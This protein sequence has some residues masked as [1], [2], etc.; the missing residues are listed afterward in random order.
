MPDVDLGNFAQSAKKATVIALAAMVAA[1]VAIS[2]HTIASAMLGPLPGMAAVM[3]VWG[4]LAWVVAVTI[5]LDPWPG[6]NP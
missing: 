6:A 2:L 3:V 4:G 5:Y 1:W